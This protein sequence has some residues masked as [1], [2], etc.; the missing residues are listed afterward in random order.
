MT[1]IPALDLAPITIRWKGDGKFGR[2]DPIC[3]P[4]QLVP[5]RD[6]VWLA[7]VR[8][9]PTT[10][11]D[12]AS[13]V[14]VTPSLSDLELIGD[15]M[16]S[17]VALYQLKDVFRKGLDQ[18][19][20]LQVTRAERYIQAATVSS[21]AVLGL[22]LRQL[23]TSS[24]ALPDPGSQRDV[25]RQVADVQR[26]WLLVDAWLEWSVYLNGSG[27][28]FNDPDKQRSRP[29]DVRVD[30]MGSWTHETKR[31]AEMFTLKIPVWLVRDPSQ[32]TQNTVICEVVSTKDAWNYVYH[33][34][35]S[36][37]FPPTHPIDELLSSVAAAVA[38]CTPDHCCGPCLSATVAVSETLFLPHL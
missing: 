15:A 2:H 16:S 29:T 9:R 23:V 28:G 3:W 33:G 10:K 6:Y 26:Y 24:D 1:W 19:V 31:A 20:H 12:Y 17:H 5:T 18:L 37:L 21:D 22:L 13:L 35:Q 27:A 11:D 30:L 38:V 4:Q 25:I 32:I 34:T 36:E 8:R 7:A 14:W